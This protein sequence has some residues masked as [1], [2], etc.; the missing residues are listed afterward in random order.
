MLPQEHPG[1]EAAG[2][3]GALKA[4]V[5]PDHVAKHIGE[6]CK[7]LAAIC[8]TVSGRN[9]QVEGSFGVKRPGAGGAA[10]GDPDGVVG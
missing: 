3:A 7:T 1:G 9:V 4:A 8:A 10:A 2:A 6:V 5:L